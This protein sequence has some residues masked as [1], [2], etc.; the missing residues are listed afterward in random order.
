MTSQGTAGRPDG[1]TAD[2]PARTV[3]CVVWDL[4]HTVWD[5]ILLED[6]EA[7]LRP[8]LREVIVELDRRGILHS[9]AS[10][11]DHDAATAALRRHGLLDYFLYPQINWNAKSS[12]IRS[13]ATSLNLGLDAFAFVDD[14][15]FERGEVSFEIPELLVLD[16]AEAAGLADRP[17]FSP[18][19]ITDD[20]ARRREMYLAD[21]ERTRVEKEF[22]GPQEA[23]LATLGMTLTIHPAQEE[24]LRRAEELTVRTH[25]LNTTGYTYSYGELDAFRRSDTHELLVARLEDR[26][27]P[28]GTIGLVLLAK[29]PDAW[30]VKLL[31]MSCRVMSR[32]VGGVIINHL[33]RRA[34]EAGV[35]LLAE[36]LPNGRNRMML[37][38]YKF[39]GFRQ[40]TGADGLTLFEADLTDV[41]GDPQ[42]LTV[43]TPSVHA[44]TAGAPTGEDRKR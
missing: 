34:R 14:D 36:Y 12:S 13:I 15:V 24:D 11:N 22:T 1:T 31:L 30:T 19:F 4:D 10:R 6:G 29:D 25:Q 7:P 39:T 40:L 38:T 21:Q 18:R 35:R 9:I 32:G 26:H 16:A 44:P 5:G 42:Y 3:K 37:I 33:R 28:Y 27:G 41:P 20:S 23:F 8:G 43:R 2:R 17:E